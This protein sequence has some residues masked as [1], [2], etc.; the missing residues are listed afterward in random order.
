MAKNHRHE[1]TFHLRLSVDIVFCTKFVKVGEYLHKYISSKLGMRHF[2]ATK[3]NGYLHLV[4]F[5]QKITYVL[6]FELKIM[7]L[8]LRLHPN[9][10][11][12]QLFL[13]FLSFFTFL[14]KLKL[15]FSV[16]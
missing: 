5:F 7:F 6:G 9:F 3:P 13:F 2:A 8:D 10:F 14:L 4:P 12:L 15:I 11:K 16:I 1:T